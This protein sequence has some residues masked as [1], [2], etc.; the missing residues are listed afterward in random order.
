MLVV[1]V[2]IGEI[3]A[4]G[5]LGLLLYKAISGDSRLMKMID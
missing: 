4:C 2:G 3:I 5:L 1:T